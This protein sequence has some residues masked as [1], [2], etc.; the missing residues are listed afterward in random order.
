[1]DDDVGAGH[2][3]GHGFGVEHVGLA[4]LGLA[5]AGR[6]RIE[7]AAGHGPDPAHVAAAL[8]GAQQRA[9]DVAGGPVTATVSPAGRDGVVRAAAG[10]RCVVRRAG[11]RGA[12]MCLDQ[13]A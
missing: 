1:M 9:A 12:G 6:L 3:L 10:L 7:G 5:Q 13:S 2:H 4:V 8:Q 11:V